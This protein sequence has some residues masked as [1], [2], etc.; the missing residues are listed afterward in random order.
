MTRTRDTSLS[1]TH[2]LPEAWLPPDAPLLLGA[3]T[4]AHPHLSKSEE[5]LVSYNTN[6]YSYAH[7]MS[8]YRIYRPRFIRL[9][10]TGK[11]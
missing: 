5:I 4:K 1:P 3:G 7:N 8:D 9:I 10:D 11:K 6:T 2:V